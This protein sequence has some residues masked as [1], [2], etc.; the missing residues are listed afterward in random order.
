LAKVILQVPI[1]RHGGE[2]FV[3]WPHDKFGQ[4]FVRSAYNLARTTSFFFVQN[5]MGKGSS[6]DRSKEEKDWKAVWSINAPSK[7]KIVL[8]RMIHD[9]LPTGTNWFG[10]TFQLTTD[11]SSVGSRSGWNT[12]F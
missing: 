4:Y 8:W 10:V 9:C 7:M 6:S 3:S 2:D 11:V 12:Y 5:F 1:S